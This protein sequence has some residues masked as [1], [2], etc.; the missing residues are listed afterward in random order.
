MDILILGGTAWLGRE[1]ATQALGRGHSVTCLA[2]GTSGAVADGATLVTADRTQPEAYDAVRDR[3]WDAVFEVSRQPG[4][5]RG[6]LDALAAR[7]RH[8]TYLSSINAYAAFDTPYADE[9]SPTREPATADEVD[10][11]LYG[12]GK[13]ASEQAST[14]AVGDR[15]VIARAGLIGGP[16]DHSCRSGAWVA[17]AARAPEEPMLVPDTPDNATQVLDVRDLASWLLDCAESGT[18]GVFD[19]V[20]PTV[21]FGEWIALCRAA[22][23]HTAPVR[24]VPAEWLVERKVEQY[25]GVDSLA[26]WLVEPGYEGW[27][28]RT[29]A[30]AL[31]AGLKH[32]AREEL[33]ADLLVWEK[34]QGLDRARKAG[35]SPDR[36]RELLAELG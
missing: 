6:A 4:Q 29:G 12:E 16:G 21:P 33:V 26:M 8:W 27:S 35:L 34:E 14:A 30:A 28:T 1:L 18:T 9:S 13:V 17:R 11:T 24:L 36:E 31:A 32:R 7:A 2:R 10:G 15:L 19:A 23:G 3:D 5:V 25:M 20:G 22:G